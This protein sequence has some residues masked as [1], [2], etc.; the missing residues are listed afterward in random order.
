MNLALWKVRRIGEAL[1]GLRIEVWEVE[2]LQT[3]GSEL[4]GTLA[5]EA[6]VLL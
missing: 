5:L 1:S 6:G 2:L 3:S 4:V